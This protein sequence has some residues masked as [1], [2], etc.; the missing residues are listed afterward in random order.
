[1]KKRL[2]LGL[3]LLLFSTGCLLIS[4]CGRTE[5]DHSK[6]AVSG[7]LRVGTPMNFRQTNPLADYH[8]SILSMLATHETLVRFDAK[9]DPV[10]QLASSWTSS[11]D[12]TIWTFSLVENAQ[13]HDGFPVTADDVKFTFE[14]MASHHPASAWLEKLIRTIEVNGSQVR[15]ILNQ[16]YSRFLINVGFVV[17]IIPRHIWEPV[18]NPL[19]PGNIQSELGC[20]PYKLTSHDTRENRLTFT[21]NESYYGPAPAYDRLEVFS[22]LTFD[23]LTRLI[24]RGDVDVYYKYASGFLPHYLP[25]LKENKKI[26]IFY[27]DGVGVPAALGFNLK[28]G[29][30]SDLN[31]RRAL[32]LALDYEKIGRSLLGETHKIPGTGFVPPALEKGLSNLPALV[33][34]PELSRK[35]FFEAGYRDT[36]HDGLLN[37][38]DSGENI[39]LKLLARS[40]LEGMD[41]L[42]PIIAHNLK[43][44]G[45]GLQINKADLSTWI[46]RV[47]GQ[48]HDLILFRTTPWGMFME[49]GCGTGYFDSRRSGGGT[50]A[51]IED[52]AFYHLCDRVL[53]NTDP[54]IEIQYYND[55]CRYYAR[56]LPALA[57]CW[58][59]NAYPCARR[60]AAPVINPI[61]GGIVNRD[62]LCQKITRTEK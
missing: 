41:A 22:H 37:H 50:L 24:M 54:T 58:S 43:Q 16:S 49:A 59:I 60:L 38:P 7:V 13:W 14:Y 17:R 55:I 29:P 53:E 31:F 20:G 42:L 28:T 52:P 8:Y 36:D 46:V 51:N 62:V 61:E 18:K 56:H 35:R 21:K 3:S 39:E 4:G 2:L 33:F 23:N 6:K 47:R 48:Q 34:S 5:A 26:H 25:R 9:M 10:P 44:V 57:L 19:Q 32:C 30:G 15:F 45:I 27:A 12:A 1:M 40:D 11:S